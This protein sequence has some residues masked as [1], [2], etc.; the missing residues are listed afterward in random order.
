MT[1]AAELP[2]EKSSLG[3]SKDSQGRPRTACKRS[4]MRIILIGTDHRL[5][6][7]VVQ[8]KTTKI[9]LPRVGGDRYRKLLT[10]CIEKCGVKAI[11]EET[12]PDQEKTVPTIASTTAKKH[13]VVWQSLGLGEPGP[14]DALI[15]PPLAEA[16]RSKVRPELLAG[17]YALETQKV[18]EEFMHSAIME[19]LRKH[20]NVLAIV[21]FV[22]LGVLARMFEENEVPVTALLF[23]YPLVV[24][25]TRS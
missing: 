23:T 25:E 1:E 14:S 22:H 11:L 7:S 15:D 3:D 19:A 5:Q 20:G 24:D 13:S 10:Y 2:E 9:W 18:R 8:D 4:C 16:I 17:I 6:T 12:H 21:G